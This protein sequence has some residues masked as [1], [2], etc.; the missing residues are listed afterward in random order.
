M[1]GHYH[2]NA[3][4]HAHLIRTNKEELTTSEIGIMHPSAVKVGF[5]VMIILF[6][7]VLGVLIWAAITF[8]DE[9]PYTVSNASTEDTTGYVIYNNRAAEP[10]AGTPVKVMDA[11]TS[12]DTC[13]A[14]C[15]ADTLC[16]FFTLDQTN[17][18]CY[19]YHSGPFSGQLSTAAPPGPTQFNASVYVKKGSI[20]CELRGAL[21]DGN[22]TIV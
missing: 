8:A 17:S 18:K 6:L 15:T 2:R 3:A 20:V 21:R 22:Q 14:A 9:K 19:L 16:K 7:G 12:S 5:A 11:V 13:T 1:S 4:D 10:Y